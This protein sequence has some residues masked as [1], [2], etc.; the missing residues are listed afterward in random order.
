MTAISVVKRLTESEGDQA[1]TPA[2]VPSVESLNSDLRAAALNGSLEALQSAID[3]GGNVDTVGSDGLTP[4]HTAAGSGNTRVAECL[5]AAKANPNSQCP[6]TKFS[7]LHAASQRGHA[8]IVALL[9][10][11]GADPT[12]L[13]KRQKTARDVAA[14]KKRE[15]VVDL[16]DSYN[17]S[18]TASQNSGPTLATTAEHKAI[19]STTVG[20]HQGG[21]AA[22]ALEGDE[23]CP[24]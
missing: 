4:L 19:T 15:D 2:P 5:I 17:S 9:L 12:L 22:G 3:A 11:S 23:P 24:A 16:L 18:S 1:A 10:Q 8:Q 7:A 13:N 14:Q 21:T 6:R 20:E